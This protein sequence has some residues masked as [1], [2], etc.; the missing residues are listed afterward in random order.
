MYAT[1]SSAR[2]KGRIMARVPGFESLFGR[3]MP[4]RYETVV[5]TLFCAALVTTA[6]AAACG[7][8][9]SSK[10]AAASSTTP[11]YSILS[12]EYRHGT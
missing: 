1:R 8:G 3:N 7:C 9:A 12:I 10:S 6:S 11:S 2:G 5:A 4:S